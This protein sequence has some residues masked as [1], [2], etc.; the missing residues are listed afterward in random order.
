MTEFK[1]AY[2][3][4]FVWDDPTEVTE[5]MRRLVE[6]DVEDEIYLLVDAREGFYV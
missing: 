6:Q 5:H 2:Q 1:F 3:L 4:L